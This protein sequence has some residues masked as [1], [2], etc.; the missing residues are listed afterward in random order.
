MIQPLWVPS[1]DRI[2][3]AAM[4]AFMEVVNRRHGLA[5]RSYRELWGWSVDHI[6]DCWAAVWDFVGIIASRGYDQV[7]DDL[8]R[9]PGARWCVGARLNFAQNLLRHGDSPHPA[10]LFRSEDGRRRVLTYAELRRE[11]GR[12]AA[13]LRAVGVQPGDRVVAYMPNV[14]ETVIAMLAA[15]SLGATWASCATDLGP[16]AALDRLGQLSPVV[17]FTADGYVY[18]GERYDTREKAAA[19]AA[20]IPSLRQVVVVPSAA[21]DGE[22]GPIPRAVRWEE[23]LAPEASPEYVQLPFDHPLYI[24]FSSGTTGK[25]KC[26]V[27]GAGG[28]LL[29]HLKELVLHTDLTA[30]DRIV[31]LTTCSWMMWNWL[32]S[33]LA[34]GATVVLYDGHPA[35]PRPDALWKMVEEERLTVVGVSASYLN[36]LR[37]A[38]VRPAATC[39]L[40]SLR[41]ISQTGSPLSPEGFAYVYREIKADVHLN[42]ISGG[43][44]INGCF[45]AGSPTLPV[46]PG[47]TQGPALAMRV[48]AYD[49]EG[50]PVYD[51][52]G[53]LVCEAPA[54][55]MPLYFWDDPDGRKYLEA[56]F[57]FYPH[58]R[59]WRH[60]DYITIH[61]DTGGI[62]FHGR[63]D[64][65]L[66]PSGVRIG[67]AEIYNVVEKL[68]GVADSL[69]VGQPWGGDQ[70]IVLFVKMAP[71][72]AFGPEV[73][74]RIRRALRE[75]ASPRHVP[76]VILEA[77]DIPYTLNM[78]KVESAVANILAGRPV[79]NREAL[80]NPETLAYFERIRDELLRLP[81]QRGGAHEGGRDVHPGGSPS[82][83]VGAAERPGGSGAGHSGDHPSRPPG[84]GHVPGHH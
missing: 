34:V 35:W 58:R 64:T 66:K 56:Y 7:V 8:T 79:V 3:A 25:P 17:L 52:P 77:P 21:G 37:A 78:K 67:T 59:V 14:P 29:N 51:R 80:I 9:F 18:K 42:S 47:Q 54:P 49:E 60:G 50:S 74:D 41:E 63:S 61:S 48:R 19:V 46:Y 27:Q 4:T 75:Q 16:A 73:A 72:H 28:V 69:A 32:V 26:M 6:A 38:G 15:A 20:G 71:G 62:T 83:G 12:L 2:R 55:S 76:A 30:R 1:E 82:E 40:S 13:S 11:V 33:A 31:Y 5:L 23:F 39:D 53:E 45:A 68:E 10:L 70:R 81:D 36:A 57:T 65:V 22:P 44:D 43:T 84:S 24:M